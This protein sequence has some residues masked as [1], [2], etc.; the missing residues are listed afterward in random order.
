M[1]IGAVFACTY[2]RD[3][4]RQSR[5]AVAGRTPKPTLT[6]DKDPKK[7]ISSNVHTVAASD[8]PASKEEKY[9]NNT[10]T[11]DLWR[12]ILSVSSQ[13]LASVTVDDRITSE[14]RQKLFYL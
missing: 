12:P 2:R 9:S 4:I 5:K 13:P 7:T 8:Q 11:N 10:D 14:P 3:L 6:E 1:T